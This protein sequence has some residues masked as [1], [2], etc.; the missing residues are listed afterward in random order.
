MRR[1]LWWILGLGLVVGGV[2]MALSTPAAS[3]DFGWFAY[4]PSSDHSEWH[5]GWGD[6]LDSATA[7]IVSRWA[8][9][10]YGVAGVGAL[11]LTAGI[12]FQMGRR[13]ATPATGSS[14]GQQPD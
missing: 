13:R 10:G 5:M 9:A 11:I 8:L 2:A 12:A 4:A 14:P 6:P 1:Q 3:A 7:V